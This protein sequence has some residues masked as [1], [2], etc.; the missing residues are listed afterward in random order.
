VILYAI[1]HFETP[2]NRRGIMQGRTDVAIDEAA[3]D[4]AGIAANRGVLESLPPTCVVASPLKRA[5]QSARAYGYDDF[6]V[7]PRLAEY[8]FGVFEGR[9]RSQLLE[10]DD[11]VWLQRFTAS[12]IGEGYDAFRR[13]LDGF[14]AETLDGHETALIFSHGVVIRY[15]MARLG[16]KDIDRCQALQVENNQLV[17]LRF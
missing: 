4:P 10:A 14:I 1:R 5:I 2:Y 15:L 3:V 13:R 12:R 9:P 11:G 8:D 16:G 7:D 17:Q 6:A